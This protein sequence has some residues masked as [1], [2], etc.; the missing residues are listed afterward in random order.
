M[1]CTRMSLGTVRGLRFFLGNNY[2]V[3]YLQRNKIVWIVRIVYGGRDL[4]QQLSD[5]IIP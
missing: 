1:L 2:V 3:F 5:E 4:K